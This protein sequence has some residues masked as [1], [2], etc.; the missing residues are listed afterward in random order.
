MP[1]TI[2]GYPESKQELTKAIRELIDRM[3]YALGRGDITD[4]ITGATN[5]PYCAEHHEEEPF[6]ECGV[7]E[8]KR[9]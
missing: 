2:T 5:V 4:V 9:R 8:I 6:P 1:V 7:G 3:P